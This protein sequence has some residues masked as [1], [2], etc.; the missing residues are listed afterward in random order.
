M[1]YIEI[2]NLNKTYNKGQQAEVKALKGISLEIAKGDMVAVMGPSGSGKSTLLNILGCL[3]R[4]DDGGCVIDTYDTSHMKDA[5]LAHFR[6]SV[7]GFVMQDFGLLGERRVWENVAIPL[8]FG[9]TKWRSIKKKCAAALEKLNMKEM[10]NRKS[11]QL[12]GG[13]KQRVAIARAIVNTPDIILADEPTGAL[14]MKTANEVMDIF[15][16][17][18]REGKTVIVVTHNHAVAKRCQYVVQLQDGKLI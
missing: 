6:N 15:E 13:Q 7:M 3:D 17:L 5:Q 10:I 11:T 1:S 9:K 2:K 4:P 16:A 14:D 18:N 12:S 8:F